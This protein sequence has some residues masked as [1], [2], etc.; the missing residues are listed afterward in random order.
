MN[1]INVFIIVVVIGV[2]F[3]I[4]YISKWLERKSKGGKIKD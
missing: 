2:P 1:L 3:V 4:I